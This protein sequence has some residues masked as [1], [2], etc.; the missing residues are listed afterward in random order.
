MIDYGR[1]AGKRIVHVAPRPIASSPLITS[2]LLRE[3]GYDSRCI[4]SG[5]YPDGRDFGCDVHPNEVE[6]RDSLLNEAD[7]IVAHDGGPVRAGWFRRAVEQKSVCVVYHSQPSQ[8]DRTLERQGAPVAVIGQYQPR[9]YGGQFLVVANMIPL[10]KPEYRPD[11]S[12]DREQDRIRI[13]YAPSNTSACFNRQA[14]EFWD[15]KG[16]QI[17][18]N[19]LAELSQRGDVEVDVISGCELNE[20]LGRKRRAHVVIDECVTGSYHRSSLEGL[21][22]GAVVIN[23]ADRLSLDA[24]RH[25]AG[26]PEPPFVISRVDGL[27]RTL[28]E[29]IEAGPAVLVRRGRAGRRWMEQCWSPGEL[30]RRGY[31]PLLA[32]A[33]RISTA[34]WPIPEKRK[35]RNDRE[36]Q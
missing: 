26:G 36:I 2:R 13:V 19:V 25:C 6:L 24:A 7:I 33:R 22:A 14:P 5:K 17:T 34:A 35:D 15:N 12:P 23:A 31:E 30:I 1:L 11:E 16:Y 8:V 32:S 9:L 18:V 20:C 3:H 21:A 4:A 29:L 27:L 28:L 10:D